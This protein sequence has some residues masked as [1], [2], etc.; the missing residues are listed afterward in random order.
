MLVYLAFKQFDLKR[1][2]L[3]SM[4]KT[5]SEL[6]LEAQHSQLS[7]RDGGF[8]KDPEGGGRMKARVLAGASHCH[9]R[10]VRGSSVPRVLI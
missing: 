3:I 1:K 5:R 8:W 4:M 6:A 10:A 9:R 7:R 2:P